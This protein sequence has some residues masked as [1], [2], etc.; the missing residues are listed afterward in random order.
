VSVDSSRRLIDEGHDKVNFAI[1]AAGENAASPHHHA[2]DRVITAGEVVLCDFGGTM[3]GYCSDITRC[4][5]LGAPPTEVAEAYA[6]LFDAQARGVQSATIGTSCQ[7]VDAAARDVIVDAGYGD[8]FIHRTGHGIGMEEHEDPYIVSGNDLALA[9]GHAFSI[10]PASTPPVVGMPRRYR[11]RHRSGP[12]ALNTADHQLVVV[13]Q[14]APS[15]S[16]I[17]GGD[18]ERVAEPVAVRAIVGSTPETG[19]P[20]GQ[21]RRTLVE[22]V[23][24]RC[25]FHRRGKAER[26]RPQR[27]LCDSRRTDHSSAHRTDDPL[28]TVIPPDASLFQPPRR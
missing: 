11:G 20:D 21:T 15:A 4:V 3:A 6:V 18:D 7:A 2:G 12:Q 1:V 22:E 27:E 10:E 26:V 8:L 19:G 24:R 25:R 5:S 17:R 23:V 28:R 14:P 16:L 13:A 9:P